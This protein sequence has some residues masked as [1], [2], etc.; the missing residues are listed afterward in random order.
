MSQFDFTLALAK[1]AEAEGYNVA[2]DTTGFAPTEQYME[3]CP[4]I[5]LFLLT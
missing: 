3:I 1:P 5:N 2:L 4:Y